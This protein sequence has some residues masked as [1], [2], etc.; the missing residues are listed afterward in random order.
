MGRM[1]RLVMPERI[2]FGHRDWQVM[3]EGA[4]QFGSILSFHDYPART[5]PLMFAGL[6][7]VPFPITMTN[8]FRF[9]Q[10][11]DAIGTIGLRVKQM[12]SGNDA[13]KT[14][15][16][17]LAQDSDDLQSGRSVYGSHHFSLAVRASSL[18]ELDRRVA[19]AQS[20]LSDAGVTSVRETDAIKPAFYAQ[21]PGNLR[22]RPRPALCKSINAVGMAAKHNVPRGSYEGRWGAPIAMMRTTA[23]TEYAFHFHV[24]GS[25]QFAAEDLGNCLLIGPSGSGKAQPLDAKVLTPTGFR[26]MGD[27]AKGDLVIAP[28]GRSAPITGVYPQGE[29]EIYRVTF[30]DGRAA[31]CCDDHL[32]KVWQRFKSHETGKC[33]KERKAIPGGGRWQV[34]PLSAIRQRLSK[35]NS[36]SVATAIPLVD[37]YA[38]ELPPQDLPI[39]P[40]ALGALLGDGCFSKTSVRLTTADDHILKRVMGDLPAYKAFKENEYDYRLTLQDRTEHHRGRRRYVASEMTSGIARGGHKN[41][42]LFIEYEGKT[43]S[44]TDWA[45]HTGIPRGAIYCRLGSLGWP[46][47]E[48]L[49][50]EPRNRASNSIAPL[51][52]ALER[53]GLRCARSHEKFVP[54]IYKRGSAAQRLA[55]LQGLLDTDGS[56]GNGTHATFSST[57]E[58]LAKDVQELAWSLGAIAKIAQRQTHFTYKGIRKAGLSSWRVSIVHPDVSLLFSLPSKV[59]KCTSKVMRHRLRISSID[60]VGR[61]LAQ[62][63]AIDHPDHLYIT[64]DY[65]V[66]HNTGLMG[67]VCLL[68]LRNPSTRV[69]IVDKDCGLSVMVR[70]AGGSYLVLPSG[71]PSGLAPLLGLSN[72][73]DD[74]AFIERFVR[75]LIMADGNGELSEDED[76]RLGRAV[77]R[78]MD[79]PPSMRSLAGIAV[80]LGQ[81]ST[82][83]AA[84]RLRKWCRGE[85]LGWA[86]DNERDELDMT[87]RIV[88]F[89]T[90]ALLRDELVCSP[91]LSYLFYRTRKLI[92]GQP[93]VL[94]ID[95]FWQTDKVQAFRDENND[96]LKTLR[97][98]EGVVLLAT[99]SARDALNSPNAHTFQQQIP[100]K[101]FFGDDSA[102]HADLVDGL[103]LTEAEYLAVTQQLPI[104]RHTFLIRR[105]GGSVLCRFDLSGAR[106]KIAVVSGRRSTYDLMNRLIARHGADPEAWVPHFERLAPGVVDEPTVAHLDAAE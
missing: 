42:E 36:L 39:S 90:T 98:N 93:I 31:E 28:D 101:I 9:R 15:V 22:W 57:S 8:S 85:R 78:Q 79:M 32:W 84:A 82:D 13:A 54:E 100:T 41:D 11:A 58:R 48:A 92:N 61:K 91:T 106:D 16:A 105:P 25:A 30:A 72:S 70:A 21:V 63:I 47:G 5:S 62:C 33:H 19:T 29:K 64:D 26:C 53:L 94:A 34:K 76:Q 3:G 24:Q 104:L 88:G 67:S 77:A 49:G 73:D 68:A 7:N 59:A 97:K 83:G 69:V 87:P 86:F 44:I 99:Q 38:I 6:R 102:N 51:T 43:R 60:P 96:H 14:Q 103:G 56:V 17:E 65:I 55:V 20:I 95:E 71:S 37:P 52:I 12:Q 4:P 66:T 81:R 23:D 74:K 18:E 27:L 40:Y 80:M 89:D 46:I 10:K 45:A 35:G 50:I 1:G 75:G 2:V